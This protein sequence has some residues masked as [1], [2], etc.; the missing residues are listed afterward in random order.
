MVFVIACKEVDVCLEVFQDFVPYNNTK[1]P[2]TQ[3]IN[4]QLYLLLWLNLPD[5]LRKQK[6]T[7]NIIV[8][9]FRILFKL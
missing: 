3:I 4:I 9:G 5:Y 2:S 6:I 7:D 1:C 8:N